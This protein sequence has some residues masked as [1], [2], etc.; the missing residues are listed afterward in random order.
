MTFHYRIDA[1]QK[2][3]FQTVVG[4]LLDSALVHEFDF[5]LGRIESLDQLR[6]LSDFSRA[7]T[8][9]L[10]PEGIRSA[11]QI[12]RVRRLEMTA[13]SWTFVAPHDLQYAQARMFSMR[14]E[15]LGVRTS[16]HRTL[17][18]AHAELGFAPDFEPSGAWDPP[19]T[20]QLNDAVAG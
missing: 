12:A 13:R 6:M 5:R 14:I 3:L 15:A 9:D 7:E 1:E 17:R 19:L 20:V 10:T 16:V 2:V 11:V 8:S 18:Q 4:P